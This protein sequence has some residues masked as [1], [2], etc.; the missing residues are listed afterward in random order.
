MLADLENGVTSLWLVRR[1]GRPA[2]TRL[3]AALDGVYLD[4]AP[5]ALDAGA[6][7]AAAADAFL[8]LVADRGLDPDAARGSLGADPLGLQ[9]RTGAAADLAGARRARRPRAG[10]TCGRRPSTRPSTTTPALGAPRSWP[11][12]PRPGSPTCGR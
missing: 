7:T 6:Q 8:R 4:L 11:L 3:A 9:A 5:V 12:G 10:R 2:R 1:R